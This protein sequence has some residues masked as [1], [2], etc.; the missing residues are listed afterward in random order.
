MIENLPGSILKYESRPAFD[1]FFRT[2][3]SGTKVEHPRPADLK[4]AKNVQIPQ[5]GLVFDHMFNKDNNGFV[6]W[7]STMQ[8]YVIPE[9]SQVWCD[10]TWFKMFSVA[11]V[12]GRRY[13]V[14]ALLSTFK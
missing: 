3:C 9:D 12:T 10:T 6:P 11:M 7:E 5:K 4:M 1:E 2:L 14:L 13:M 8:R